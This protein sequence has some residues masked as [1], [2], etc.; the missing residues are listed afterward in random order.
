MSIFRRKTGVTG[1]SVI[2]AWAKA[3]ER[4]GS[5][6]PEK[7]RVELEKFK[8]EPFV[9]GLTTFTPELHINQQRPML[10]IE[11]KDGKTY[12]ARLL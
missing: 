3:A 4:A 7:V 9:A 1:Y 6:Q 11:T 12:S 2:E 10:I 8:D 5:T